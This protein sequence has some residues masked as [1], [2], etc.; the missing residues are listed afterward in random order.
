[1]G[2]DVESVQAL[3]WLCSAR[4]A[5]FQ[6]GGAYR[7]ETSFVRSASFGTLPRQFL[8]ASG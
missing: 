7:E 2:W 5:S 3:V 4:A 1:M 8:E 6:D